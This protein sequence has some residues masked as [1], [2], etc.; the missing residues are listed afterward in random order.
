MISSVLVN[1]RRINFLQHLIYET[2]F[3]SQVFKP[4]KMIFRQIISKKH[5]GWVFET[6]YSVAE[7]IERSFIEFFVFALLK[8]LKN[9][10][11]KCSVLTPS[12][13]RFFTVT[14]RGY[15]SFNQNVYF[16]FTLDVCLLKYVSVFVLRNMFP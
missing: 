12:F 10:T 5:T 6:V 4:K 9:Q 14:S 2:E 13:F 15:W 11:N 16:R 3:D 7:L 8:N 1:E